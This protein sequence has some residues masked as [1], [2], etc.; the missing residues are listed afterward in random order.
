[1]DRLSR[2]VWLI[3]KTA[4]SSIRLISH[5]VRDLGEKWV[6]KAAGLDRNFGFRHGSGHHFQP[7]ITLGNADLEGDVAHPEP[8]MA[9]HFFVTRGS[10]QAEEQELR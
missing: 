5:K 10:T 9:A 7:A 4:K 1:M 8:R 3:G 6:E 2:S